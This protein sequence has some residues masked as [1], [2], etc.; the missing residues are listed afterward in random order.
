MEAMA[1]SVPA[2]RHVRPVRPIE[3]P[4]SDPEW[5]M[6]QTG[7]H[8]RLCNA[9]YQ[10]LRDALA[11]ASLVASDQFLYFDAADNRKKCAPDVLVKLGAPHRL[12]DTWKTWED[13]TPDLCVEILSSSDHEKLTLDEKLARYH[14]IG[15][16]EVVALDPLALA[17]ARLRAWDR[18]D[19][20]LV[21]RVVDD[22]RTPCVTLGLWLVLAPVPEEPDVDVALRLARDPLGRD[23][24]PTRA[25][26]ARAEK[27]AAL[28]AADRERAA[29][30][31]ERA[32]ADRERAAKEAALEELARLRARSAPR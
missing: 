9:L 29:A 22:E 14:A 23:L 6:G 15:V 2:V 24:L 26:R 21:E 16:P 17:G 30:D 20:D 32:A 27:E 18:V 8:Q 25:E 4:S 31:R 7:L 10:L 19:G 5:D 3:F 13:G 12:V 1:P 11:P 28:A